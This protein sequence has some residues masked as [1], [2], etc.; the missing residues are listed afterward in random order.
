MGTPLPLVTG[1]SAGVILRRRNGRNPRARPVFGAEDRN[2]EGLH[3]TAD[4]RRAETMKAKFFYTGIRVTDL[5]AS[6]TFYRT[7]LG[8]AG[9]GRNTV[10]AAKGPAVRLDCART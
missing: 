10:A 9:R 5:G 2:R 4:L 1:L 8:A 6:A 7:L 3:P